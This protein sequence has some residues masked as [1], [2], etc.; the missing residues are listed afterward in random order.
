M[1][2]NNWSDGV[3]DKHAFNRAGKRRQ[4]NAKRKFDAAARK[5]FIMKFCGNGYHRLFTEW[6]LQT[7][8]AEELEVSRATICRDVQVIQSAYTEIAHNSSGV[9]LNPSFAEVLQAVKDATGFTEME[10]KLHR[11]VKRERNNGEDVEFNIEGEDDFE[12]GPS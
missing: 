3:T 10:K 11:E 2:Q 4:Y 8:L 1:K 7:Q 12:S 6:G 9:F 5:V